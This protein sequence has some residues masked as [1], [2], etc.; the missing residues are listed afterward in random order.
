MSI[1]VRARSLWEAPESLPEGLF[2]LP[3]WMKEASC[4]NVNP[5][6]FFP[7][8]GANSLTAKRICA[9]CAVRDQCLEWALEQDEEYG[10][11]GGASP[12]ERRQIQRARRRRSAGASRAPG[13]RLLDQ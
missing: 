4:A 11:F 13:A 7:V 9:G 2:N 12:K 5:D 6:L 3:G 8:R 1:A 10:V